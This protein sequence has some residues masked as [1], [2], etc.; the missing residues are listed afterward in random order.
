MRIH[1]GTFG[2]QRVKVNYNVPSVDQTSVPTVRISWPEIENAAES[3]SEGGEGMS[4]SWD[5]WACHGTY[6]WVLGRSQGGSEGEQSVELVKWDTTDLHKQGEVPL[7]SHQ[8]SVQLRCIEVYALY[9]LPTSV[10][11]TDT[12]AQ[13]TPQQCL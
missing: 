13:D 4:T 3:N 6:H 9:S 2:G 5:S 8:H 11:A 1:V 7:L 10:T 12:A